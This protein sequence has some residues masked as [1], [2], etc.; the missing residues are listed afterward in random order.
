MSLYTETFYAREITE[1]FSDRSAIAK[2]LQVEAALAIAQAEVGIIPDSAAKIISDCCV[3]DAIDT[4][5]L[6]NDIVLGGNV[7]IP[8]VKQLTKIIK[9]RDFEASK[10]VHLG[11]T[12]Q[13]IIDTATIL[14][15]KEYLIWLE[16]KLIRLEKTLLIQTKNHK[17]TLM[18]GRTLLQQAK[19][20]TF[21][22]KTAGWLESISRAKDRIKDVKKR[23]LC[24]QLGGAVGSGNANITDEVQAAFAKNLQ[25][26]EVFP[27]QSQRDS[28]VEF[29]SFLGIL[30]GSLG[31]IAK[32]ISLLMQT[33]VAEVFEGAAES[34]GGSS[35]MPHKRNPVSCALI[36]SNATRTP[37]LVSTMLSALPQEHERSA[38]LWHA[39]WETLTQLMNLT[40]GSLVK[41]VDLIGNLEVDKDRMLQNIEITNGL[42]YAERVSLYLSKSL[43]KMQA[44]E[45][46]KKACATAIQKH[47]HLKDVVLEMY[48]KIENIEEL[49]KPENAIGNSVSWVETLLKKYS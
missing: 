2:L 32:D 38:G 29:A 35:T 31:K 26:Q 37:G 27:W 8:L 7:A 46:V 13:D 5:S 9:N 16:E 22:L 1:L 47:K 33:E 40:S 23:L 11:A 19:P 12:S 20:I 43:G 3:I 25:L 42:I 48:P 45:S 49:F 39:E 4:I 14:T 17:H 15:I 30:S 6:K 41:S 18:I 10:Y 34:K 44:H 36:L 21:G 24:I 28:L